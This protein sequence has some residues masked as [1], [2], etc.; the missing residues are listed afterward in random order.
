MPAETVT[1]RRT[2]CSIVEVCLPGEAPQAAGVV[3]W[4]PGNGEYR[5]RFRRDW[6]AF[7]GEDAEIL[8]SL[9]GDFEAKLA[10]LG[11]GDWLGQCE[12]MLS[13]T[14]RIRDREAVLAEDL[15][16]AAQ[17]L[18]AR[19]VNARVLAFVTHLPK[20]SA[21]VAAGK[22]LDDQHVE[23]EEWIEIPEGIRL[24]DDMFLVQ[25]TGRSMEPRIPDGS[26][27]VFRARTAGSRQGKLL[28]IERGDLPE[29]GRYTVKRYRSE[30]AATEEGWRHARIRLEPLNPEFEAWDL[31]DDPDRFRVIGE[32]VAVVE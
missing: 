21:R 7:A 2:F 27:C 5:L 14:L 15:D 17:Q 32:F 20:Y 12:Q 29:S 8:A 23:A 18:Y 25:I 9:A 30:K 4:D 19:H 1:T 6:D 16:R 22:F 3:V 28:L 10:E 26:L 11:A 24:D 13:N 31:E